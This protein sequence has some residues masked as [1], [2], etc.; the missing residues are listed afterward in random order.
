[1]G[2]TDGAAAWAAVAANPRESHHLATPA[3]AEARAAI[4]Q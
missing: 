3:R 4:L 1:M 2:L